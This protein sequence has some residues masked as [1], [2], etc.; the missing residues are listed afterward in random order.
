MHKT[1]ATFDICIDCS[2]LLCRIIKL[3]LTHTHP[4]YGNRHWP[5]I[6]ASAESPALHRLSA[7]W[8]GINAGLRMLAKTAGHTHTHVHTHRQKQ[9]ETLL[10]V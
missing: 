6:P 10:L 2:H 3:P 4:R 9:N 5:M 1:A 7:P 8:H